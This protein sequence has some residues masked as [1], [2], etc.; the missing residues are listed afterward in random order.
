ML[1]TNYYRAELDHSN[2]LLFKVV[3]YEGETYALMLEIIRQH[4]YS[5]SRFLNGAIVDESKI[6]HPDT[7]P[8]EPIHNKSL[9]Y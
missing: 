6:I 3:S 7:E 8:A 1:P 2:R 5:Q 9:E 4:D